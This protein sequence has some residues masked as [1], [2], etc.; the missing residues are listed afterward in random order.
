MMS[1]ILRLL[2]ARLRARTVLRQE[3]FAIFGIAVGVA[4]LF[5]SQVANT[6]LTRSAAQL[7]RQVVGASQFQLDARGPGGFDE[8]LLGRVERVP[9]V[10]AAVPV[11]EQEVD[12]IG[13]HGQRSVDLIGPDPRFADVSGPLLQH[14]SATQLGVQHALALPAPLARAIG[15]GSLETVKLQVGARV[16]LT[17]L[18]ATLGESEIGGLVDSPIALVPLR[19]AQ[20]L[21]GMH[22]RITRI[23]I[24]CEPGQEDL[25]GVA[26]TRLAGAAGVEL[27]PGDYDS[28][29]FAV[30]VAPASQSQDLFSAISALVGFMFALNAMLI[31]APARR[32]LIEGIRREGATRSKLVQ[33]LLFDAIVLGVLG[34]MLGLVLGDVLSIAF[35]KST[36][37]YLAFA[38]PVGSNRIVGAQSVALAVLAGMTAAVVGVL[39]PLRHVLVQA[40]Q[41]EDV[42]GGA[43]RREWLVARLAIGLLCLAFTAIIPVVH[44]RGEVVGNVLLV[45]A[46][47]CLLPLLFDGLVA[48][49][50]RAQRPL[51]SAASALA[52]IEL[53]T[54]RTRVRSLAI[55]TTAAVAVFGIVEFHGIQRNLT[56]GLDSSARSIDSGAQLW[57]TPSGEASTLVTVPF[58]DAYSHALARLPGVQA[59]GLYRGGFLNWGLRRL[60]ILAPPASSSQPIPAGQIV[61]GDLTLAAMRVRDGGW[62]VV[63]QVLATEHHLHVGQA[64]VLPSPRSITLRV[65]G[66]SNNLGWPPGTIV[67]SAVDYAQAWESGDP[68]AY[69]I[70]AKPD[71]TIATVQTEV[72]RAL[73]PGTGLVVETVSEREQRHYTLAAQGLARLTQIRLLVLIAAVLAVTAAMG[74]LVWQRRDRI[75][76]MKRDG[77]HRGVLWRWLVCESAVLLGTGC[78]IGAVFGLYGDLLGSHFLA[79]ETGFPVVIQVQGLAALSSFALVSLIAVAVTAVPGFLVARVP[80]GASSSAY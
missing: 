34:C 48:I 37:G 13:P 42:T 8:K 9:G 4:L 28:R 50:E 33:I 5:A 20:R 26:L 39:W 32:R 76:A 15:A 60:W 21:T 46:L 18:G 35:F 12:V 23:F 3:G 63:S 71:T 31:T 49:F 22:G 64:F 27:E 29:L 52:V 58:K 74:S 70:Q 61:S 72:R 47:V 25:V 69:A 79:R 30:A 59:V 53:R 44:S 36:P 56:N 77:Y 80:P 11:L 10:R 24:R 7:D 16:V 54:S 51:A 19:Y 78:S 57:V 73:G 65:A 14:F 38:F 17:L 41:V 1:S 6:S 75:A 62:A 45:I 40:W 68:S 55:A 43:H 2:R 67:M 66:V